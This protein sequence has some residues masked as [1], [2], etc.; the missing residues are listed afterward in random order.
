MSKDDIKF[1]RGRNETVDS[2]KGEELEV[3]SCNSIH[4]EACAL[5][6]SPSLI[7]SCHLKKSFVLGS[8]VSATEQI[9]KGIDVTKDFLDIQGI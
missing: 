8:N 7:L 1:Q 6:F 4:S 2:L 5:V 9:S 3:P